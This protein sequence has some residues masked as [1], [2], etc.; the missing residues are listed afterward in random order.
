MPCSSITASYTVHRINVT[1]LNIIIND[2]F[3]NGKIKLSFQNKKRVHTMG[4]ISLDLAMWAVMQLDGNIKK[5][6][7]TVMEMH[8]SGN[9][10][11]LVIKGTF[12]FLL[13]KSKITLL[14]T[15]FFELFPSFF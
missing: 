9:K 12:H 7:F 8:V 5:K 2:A 1:N 10:C 11:V 14:Y 4:V 13:L 6:I 15:N 3:C